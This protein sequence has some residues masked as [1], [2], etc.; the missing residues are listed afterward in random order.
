MRTKI[1]TELDR[2][3]ALRVLKKLESSE[4]STGVVLVPKPGGK[5]RLCG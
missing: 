4:W 3:I 1:K 5:I 2:L